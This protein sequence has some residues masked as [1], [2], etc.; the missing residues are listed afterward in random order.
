M[1]SA[2][3]FGLGIALARPDLK[4]VVV[5]GDGAAL[6]RM[7]NFATVGIYGKDNLIHLLLDNQVHDSTGAQA[8]VSK[9]IS[10]AKVAQGCGYG[11]CLE[12]NDVSLVDH[13]FKADSNGKT[14]FG[15]LKIKKGTIDNLPRPRLSP[16]ESS[17]RLM[18]HLANNK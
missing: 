7:G 15:H 11:L 16:S 2:S 17:K 1:G 14:R 6:M 10:F 12:G 8:T 5:D 3:S 4:V 13:L 9:G 18:N